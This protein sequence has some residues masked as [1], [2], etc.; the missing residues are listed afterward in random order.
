MLG[1]HDEFLA[2]SQAQHTLYPRQSLEK[3]CTLQ[4]DAFRDVSGTIRF[5]VV[6]QV[7]RVR[8]LLT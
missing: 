6:S 2:T 3:D 8:Q 5:G 1:K 7:S 4:V